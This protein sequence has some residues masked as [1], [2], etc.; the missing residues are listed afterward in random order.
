[1]THRT[2]HMAMKLNLAL[3]GTVLA[4][5][6]LSAPRADEA[7]AGNNPPIT[8]PTPPTTNMTLMSVASTAAAAAA[9]VA[10]ATPEQLGQAVARVVDR[11]APED[12]APEELAQAAAEA[13]AEQFRLENR[14]ALEIARAFL[15]AYLRMSELREFSRAADKAFD[16]AVELLLS[17]G[18][19]PAQIG[20]ILS[21]LA[22]EHGLDPVE[23]GARGIGLATALSILN[24]GG[25]AQAAADAAATAA[26][27]FALGAGASADV[28]LFAGAAAAGRAA[29][30]AGQSPADAGAAAARAMRDILGGTDEQAI[31]AAGTAAGRA[32]EAANVEIGEVGSAAAAAAAAAGGT[33]AQAGSAAAQA[34]T[35]AGGSAEQAITAAGLGA[36]SAAAAAGD[37]AAFFHADMMFHKALWVVAG[38]RWASRALE[39]A[40]GSLFASGLMAALRRGT[41]NLPNEADKHHELVQLLLQGH[42]EAAAGQMADIAGRFETEV[43]PDMRSSDEES[44]R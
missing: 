40:L 7:D 23:Y 3:L 6:P 25:T 24:A 37:I 21:T 38:N 20:S 26:C 9:S 15:A 41:L 16:A 22:A 43:L 17:M 1:M 12:A 35:S 8:T 10:G 19:S 13:V 18:V 42:V 28:A 27:S 30:A 29:T 31:T 11:T 33:P 34:V 4:L 36:G 5:A 32:A 14:S 2:Q 39:T 44:A